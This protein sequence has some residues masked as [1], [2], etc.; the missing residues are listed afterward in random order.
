MNGLVYLGCRMMISTRAAIE[1]LSPSNDI[2]V[3]INPLYAKSCTEKQK[4]LSLFLVLCKSQGLELLFFL[5]F[6]QVDLECPF[7][8]YS[9]VSI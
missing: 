4:D 5:F 2:A 3:T 1:A 7:S 8:I 6:N 9:M